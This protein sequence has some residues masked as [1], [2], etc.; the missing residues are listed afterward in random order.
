M[1]LSPSA[2]GPLLTL[3]TPSMDCPK[4]TLYWGLGF[5]ACDARASVSALAPR[6]PKPS[7]SGPLSNLPQAQHGL[8]KRTH[9]IGA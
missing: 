4:Y 2:S 8:A 1:R 6:L 3:L 5:K 7:A 9:A